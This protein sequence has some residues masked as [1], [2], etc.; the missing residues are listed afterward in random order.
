MMGLHSYEPIKI[1]EFHAQKRSQF[2]ILQIRKILFVSFKCGRVIDI[3]Y[4]HQLRVF[5]TNS[6][7]FLIIIYIF[8]IIFH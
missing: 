3:I 4:S 2:S 1:S 7:H 5:S 6:Q 8:M